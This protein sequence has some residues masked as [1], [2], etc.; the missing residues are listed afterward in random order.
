MKIAVI[1]LLL[2]FGVGAA[3]AQLKMRK[4]VSTL[5]SELVPYLNDAQREEL[6]HNAELRLTEEQGG[7]AEQDS[8]LVVKNML[9]GN[10]RIDS[11]SENFVRIALND[12]VDLQVR[13][14][15]YSDSA[16][17]LCVVKTIKV[18]LKESEVSFY[19]V[20]W[21]KMDSNLGLPTNADIEG[22]LDIFAL[23]PDTM[24][25]SEYAEL[26]GLFDPIAINVDASRNDNC[27]QFELCIPVVP[28]E[29]KDEMKA[30]LHPILFKWD[31]ENFKKC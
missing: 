8:V 24:S 7:G 19:D 29:K 27:L 3:S 6:A 11:I 10:T 13:V 30:I 26:R 1:S 21:K 4:V 25:E 28:H 16:D 12:A 5:P 20:N 22:L 17:V 31:G 15:P 2:M 23:R 9:E 18:P 14:L